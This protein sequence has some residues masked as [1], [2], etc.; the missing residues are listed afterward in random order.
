MKRQI[1]DWADARNF[2]AI[3]TGGGC[4]ALEHKLGGRY[5]IL[6]TASEEPSIPESMDEPIMVGFY[7][8]DDCQVLAALTVYQGLSGLGAMHLSDLVPKKKETEKM[9]MRDIIKDAVIGLKAAGECTRANTLQGIIKYIPVDSE[10]YLMSRDRIADE[11]V[12]LRESLGGNDIMIKETG[13]DDPLD[14]RDSLIEL[15]KIIC[16]KINTLEWVLKGD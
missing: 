2:V 6:I 7:E 13:K 9:N 1:K 15:R 12:C 4:D 16:T 5:Y 3:D 8:E 11:L 14:L 10:P